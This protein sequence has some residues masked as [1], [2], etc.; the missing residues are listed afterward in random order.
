MTKMTVVQEEQTQS[1]YLEYV[2]DTGEAGRF[3]IHARPQ[4][5]KAGLPQRLV[6]AGEAQTK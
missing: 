4:D 3:L 5:V 6:E 1:Y 2:L